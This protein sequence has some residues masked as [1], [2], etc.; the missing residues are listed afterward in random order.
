MVATQRNVC[1]GQMTKLTKIKLTKGCL[2]FFLSLV[3]FE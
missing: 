3:L 1:E 2:C